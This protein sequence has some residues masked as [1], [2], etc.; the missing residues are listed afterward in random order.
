MTQQAS[1]SILPKRI[2]RTQLI[3]CV[4]S[5]AVDFRARLG[6]YTSN[7]GKFD[8][9]IEKKIKQIYK[10]V[11]YCDHQCHDKDRSL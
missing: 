7:L 10:Q 2:R 11:Y 3:V 5:L 1:G 6:H 9:R 4:L 8:S